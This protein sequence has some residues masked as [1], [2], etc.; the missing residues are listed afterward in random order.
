MNIIQMV[1]R[2]AVF[3]NRGQT[4]RTS[5][6]YFILAFS[7]ILDV[8]TGIAMLW[9]SDMG[10]AGLEANAALGVGLLVLI[11]LTHS[12]KTHLAGLLTS[13]VFWLVVTSM[14]YSDSGIF[15]PVFCGYMI[16][17]IIAGLVIHERA[18]VFFA[19]ISSAAGLAFVYAAEQGHYVATIGAT[20]ARVAWI[21]YTA[22]FVVGTIFLLMGLTILRRAFERLSLS[23]ERFRTL[24]EKSSDLTIITSADTKIQFI[25]P[26]VEVILG[27]RPGEVLGK[28]WVLLLYGDDTSP[29][30]DDTREFAKYSRGISQ[31]QYR[32]QHKDGS[33]RTLELVTRNMLHIPAV[34]GFVINARDVT[35]RVQVEAALQRSEELLSRV[36]KAVPL[37]I[38]ISTAR[39]GRLLNV[40]DYGLELTGYQADELIGR[41]TSEISIWP[42][43]LRNEEAVRKAMAEHGMVQGFETVWTMKSGE[44]RDMVVSLQPFEYDGELCLLTIALDIT[45]H[46]QAEQERLK[47]E[48]LRM[49]IDKEREV[50]ELKEKFISTMSHEFRTPL[51]IIL[52][53]KSSLEKYYDRMTPERRKEHFQN[54]EDQVRYTTSLLD[55]VLK[56]SE[57]RSGTL[58]FSPSPLNLIAFSR[59]H[60]EQIQATDGVHHRF[61]FI[62]EGQLSDFMGDEILLRHILVNLL[63]NAIKYSPEG[64]EVRLELKQA[65]DAVVIQISDEGIGIPEE[66]QK[67]LF[68][69]FYRASNVKTIKGTGLGLAIVKESVTA[70]CGKITCQSEANTGTTFT[71]WLP[72][73]R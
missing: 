37:V 34:N 16:V 2:S 27:Y 65:E 10:M 48:K 41:K 51:S 66:D 69:P 62:H 13:A 21:D 57:A 24:I 50:L 60:F 4:R 15:N 28:S 53:T 18:A 54:I 56:I 17:I 40:N 45:E 31:G 25:T 11:W 22:I 12:G 7:L 64:G 59:H 39:E 33:Y 43:P 46:K 5:L 14:V 9:A 35:E 26:S 20:T 30:K 19:V 52:T 47:S 61:A 38:G 8:V 42:T 36:F 3:D 29:N 73:G 23:E 44:K 70:H 55:D 72:M 68:E 6:L 49:E 58:H 1:M 63:S 71:V 32:I 67:H